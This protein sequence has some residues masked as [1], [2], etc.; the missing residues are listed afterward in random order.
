MPTLFEDTF[1]VDTVD[2]DGRKFD[3]VSRLEAHSDKFDMR[4]KL[5]VNVDVYPLNKSQQRFVLLLADTLNLDG[6]RDPE[7][8]VYTEALMQG[9]PSLADKYEYV[10]YGKVFK[11]VP[12]AVGGAAH[13]IIASFGGLLMSLKGAAQEL[14]DLKRDLRVFILIRK[15]DV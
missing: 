13:E 2:A 3:L 4:L 6:T 7:E 15:V 14:K 8:G 1:V 12:G 11:V 9:K 5:D 10:M